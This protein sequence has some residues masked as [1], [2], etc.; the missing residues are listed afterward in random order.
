[1]LDPSNQYHTN[2]IPRF[3][4]YNFVFW[5]QRRAGKLIS[6]NIWLMLMPKYIPVLKLWLYWLWR[7]LLFLVLFFLIEYYLFNKQGSLHSTLAIAV[8]YIILP[9][10]VMFMGFCFIFFYVLVFLNCVGKVYKGHDLKNGENSNK[11]TA[12]KKSQ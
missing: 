6:P 3:G 2:K 7:V 8:N 5:S 9:C 11:M 1:M 4:L 10:F 12:A